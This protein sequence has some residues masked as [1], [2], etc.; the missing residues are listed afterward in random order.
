MRIRKYF[1]SREF[2][3]TVANANCHLYSND[4]AAEHEVVRKAA[5]ANGA[6]SAIVS[7]HW[8]EGGS[9]AVRLAEA[10]IDACENVK[11]NFRFLYNLDTSIESKIET[12]AKEMYGA[13]SVELSPKVREAI[14]LFTAQVSASL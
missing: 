7:S 4:T 8:S 5:L 12:I 2:L 11:P 13:G 1:T 9:G 6:H 14:K 3:G 10:L